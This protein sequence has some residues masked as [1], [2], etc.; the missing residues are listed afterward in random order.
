[1]FGSVV[2]HLFN[3]LKQSASQYWTLLQID[4]TGIWLSNA[5]STFNYLYVSFYCD[6]WMRYTA[7]VIH[8][9]VTATTILPALRAK[10]P[11]TRAIALSLFLLMRIITTTSR[12]FFFTSLG[13]LNTAWWHYTMTDI[14]FFIGAII[15]AARLPEKFWPGS[16]DIAFSRLGSCVMVLP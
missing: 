9:V 11:I 1:M 15:N 7:M 5:I 2:Y 6:D 4:I 3:S 16:F 14:L 10:T 12:Q 13:S 8:A